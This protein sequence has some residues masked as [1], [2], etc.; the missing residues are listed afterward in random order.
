M[1]KLE[2]KNPQ[3]TKTLSNKH[4]DAVDARES[5]AGPRGRSR[6]AEAFDAVDDG[7]AEV[8]LLGKMVVDAGALDA[9]VRRDVTEADGAVTAVADAML[10]D[11]EDGGG[12]VHFVII[13]Q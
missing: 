12:R 7:D 9:D 3:N 4:S 1:K 8:G 5:R 2:F 11:I 10:G 13:Y 6:A